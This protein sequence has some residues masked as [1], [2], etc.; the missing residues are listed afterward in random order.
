MTVSEG[1]QTGTIEKTQWHRLLAQAVEAPLTAANIIV[2]TEIDVTSK[3]PKADIILLRREGS[4]WTEEQKAWLTDGMRDT[5][6]GEL[7]IEFKFAESLT[8]GIFK[9]LLVYD[10]LYQEKRQIERNDLKSFLLLSK[11]PNTG[12]LERHG[13]APRR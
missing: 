2:Q 13:F 8:S 9:Q 12:I 6:A 10:H 3:S 11:T 4:S 7:L 1:V 5:T